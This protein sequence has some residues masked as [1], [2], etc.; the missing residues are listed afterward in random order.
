MQ[1][2]CLG[3]LSLNLIKLDRRVFDWNAIFN[4]QKGS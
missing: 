2:M 4:E 3:I 1:T